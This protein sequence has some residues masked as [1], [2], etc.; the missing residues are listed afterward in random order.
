MRQYRRMFGMSFHDRQAITVNEDKYIRKYKTYAKRKEGLSVN[1]NS[2]F[3]SKW[4]ALN[5]LF[6]KLT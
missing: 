2:F 4:K 5:C 3:I 1:S 6:R